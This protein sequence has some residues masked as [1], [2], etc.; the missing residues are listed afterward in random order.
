M[1]DRGKKPQRRSKSLVGRITEKISEILYP[2]AERPDYGG[3]RFPEAVQHVR[4]LQE[5]EKRIQDENRRL[6]RQTID[7][8]F[9]WRSRQIRQQETE[10]R[11]SDNEARLERYDKS[12]T[13][14]E[15]PSTDSDVSGVHLYDEE[16]R[17]LAEDAA[18]VLRGGSGPRGRR[19]ETYSD[20][21]YLQSGGYT[22]EER[23]RR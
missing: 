11:R 13:R 8:N 2:K 23:K 22:V 3:P 20:K 6:D 21:D 1:P 9:G 16:E 14:W 15:R 5:A 17:K 18:R 10:Q 7:P 19:Q 4:N 12:L